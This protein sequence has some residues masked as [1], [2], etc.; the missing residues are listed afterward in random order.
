MADWPEHEDVVLKC[1]D[2]PDSRD[3]YIIDTTPLLTEPVQDIINQRKVFLADGEHSPTKNKFQ[4]V[5]GLDDADGHDGYIDTLVKVLGS[6]QDVMLR[7][8][9][10]ERFGNFT[11]WIPFGARFSVDDFM[12]ETTMGHLDIPFWTQPLAT[13]NP[14]LDDPETEPFLLRFAGQPII[15]IRVLKEK[16]KTLEEAW[17]RLLGFPVRLDCDPLT[18][19]AARA[20]ALEKTEREFRDLMLT[21]KRKT[22]EEGGARAEALEETEREF[23]GLRLTKKRTPE[24]GATAQPAQHRQE[25]LQ[26]AMTVFRQSIVPSVQ[27]SL[28]TR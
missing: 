14:D 21:L 11:S 13:D 7:N 23:R 26:T 4:T 12:T 19:S 3:H 18:K 28:N 6:I 22:P 17:E 16:K 9:V 25:I 27:C 8:D 24:G 15:R 1:R 20:E 10:P 5:H 2:D